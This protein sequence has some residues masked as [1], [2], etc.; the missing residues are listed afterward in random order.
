MTITCT[1]NRKVEVEQRE[2]GPLGK[3][4]AVSLGGGG[5]GQVWG[6]TDRRETVAT[7]QAAVDA[8]ITLL[9]VAPAYGNGEAEAV[10]GEAFGSGYPDGVRV[11]TKCMLG[12]TVEPGALGTQLEASLVASLQ[13]LRRDS[14]DAFIL[15]DLLVPDG[16]TLPPGRANAPWT[17]HLGFITTPLSL[18]FETIVPALDRLV[19]RGLAGTWGI[20]CFGVEAATREAL[21]AEHRPGL[22][23]C[24]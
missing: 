12:T 5:I 16:F 6:P 10:V 20:S 2:L 24:V 1:G 13:R 17:A 11:S 8:G 21:E 7:V 22:V 4:S 23:Q 3:V 19:R 14:V 15:H 18:Y 9:D